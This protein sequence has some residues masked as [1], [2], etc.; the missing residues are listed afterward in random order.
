MWEIRAL[1]QVERI[2]FEKGNQVRRLLEKVDLIFHKT[3]CGRYSAEVTIEK[4]KVIEDPKADY[5]SINKRFW[6]SK[7]GRK[8]NIAKADEDLQQRHLIWLPDK[9]CLRVCSLTKSLQWFQ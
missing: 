6:I 5:G 8:V 3:S 2:F 4:N 7:S 9:R 1:M